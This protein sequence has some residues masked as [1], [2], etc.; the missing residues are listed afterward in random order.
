MV[1]IVCEDI[2]SQPIDQLSEAEKDILLGVLSRYTMLKRKYER[3]ENPK[4]RTKQT[5]QCREI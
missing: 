2:L 3:E 5:E 1:L 4:K